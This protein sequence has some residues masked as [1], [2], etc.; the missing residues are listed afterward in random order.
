M[1][2]FF[3]SVISSAGHWLFVSSS[4]GLT[5]GRVRQHGSTQALP[6]LSLPAALSAQLFRRSGRIRQ[7]SLDFPQHAL[8]G[9]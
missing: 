8:L 3:V 7:V 4:G 6:Q 9:T 5:A 1:P 2:P